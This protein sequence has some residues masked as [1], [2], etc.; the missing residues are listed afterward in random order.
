MLRTT[1]FVLLAIGAAVAVPAYAKPIGPS[2]FCDRYPD[3][4]SCL[5]GTPACTFCHQGAPPARNLYG[6]TVE[7]ALLPGAPRPLSDADYAEN[8]PAALAAAEALDADHDGFSNLD[9]ITAGTLPGDDRS[10]PDVSACPRVLPN[11]N[12]DVCN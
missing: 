11:P 3:A 8:L 12:Y 7:A 5:A 2:I 1:S 9:E 4:P 10:L 6:M